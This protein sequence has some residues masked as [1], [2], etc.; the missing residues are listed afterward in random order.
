MDAIQFHHLM[1]RRNRHRAP[2]VLG[3]LFGVSAAGAAAA[4]LGFPLGFSGGDGGS[5]YWGSQKWLLVMV[6]TGY[7]DVFRVSKCLVFA[8]FYL[9]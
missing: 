9:K 4:S 7:L 6:L 2:K 1:A 3:R 5:R 8:A